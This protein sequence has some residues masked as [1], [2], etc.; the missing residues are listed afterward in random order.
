MIFHELAVVG[1]YVLEPERRSDERGFF[2][3]T[4]C[5]DE[6]GA[7]ELESV[8][9]Q[10]SVSYNAHRGTLRGM[11]LQLPPHEE[12]KVVRCTRGAVH[13]VIVDLRPDSP[14]FGEWVGAE[15]DPHNGLGVYVPRGCAHGFLT[16][17]DDTEMEYVI[18]TPHAPDVAT[19]I[20]WD[21]PAIGVEWPFEPTT[22][23]DRDREYELISLDGWRAGKGARS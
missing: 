16:L 17:R 10:I 23:S 1:A 12:T 2:A 15:L 18:S 13:D 19:G 8:V 7:H 4:F 11:H 21:D 14:S 9:A 20:R 22:M 3:R 5:V 6:L